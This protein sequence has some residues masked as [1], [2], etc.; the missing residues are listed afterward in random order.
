MDVESLLAEAERVRQA[1]ERCLGLE[2]E[3]A[4]ARYEEYVAAAAELTE[5]LAPV[6]ERMAKANLLAVSC[7]DGTG[8]FL[9]LAVEEAAEED[10]RIVLFTGVVTDRSDEL[11]ALDDLS[12]DHPET[13]LLLSPGTG[14][15]LAR[16]AAMEADLRRAGDAL[17]A[18]E[19]R[20]IRDLLAP[21]VE[22][23][24]G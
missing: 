17:H 4:R 9:R 13:A 11:P 22:A 16:L 1:W 15:A 2:G 6:V 5:R 20:A 7:E 19:A 10:A 21:E 23:H 14:E 24:D 3:E 12:G 8:R 18:D